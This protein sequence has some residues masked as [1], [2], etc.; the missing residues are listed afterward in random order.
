MVGVGGV[1]GVG[2]AGGV[3]VV[4]IGYLFSRVML[5]REVRW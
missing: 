2:G 1:C 4:G 3:G 5:Y